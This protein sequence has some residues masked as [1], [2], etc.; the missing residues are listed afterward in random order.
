MAVSDAFEKL[1]HLAPATCYEPAEEVGAMGAP[2][3]RQAHHVAVR[4]AHHV[5]VG[6]VP[7]DFEGMIQYATL[8]GGKRI[9]MLK[10][11]LTS[12]CERNCYYCPFRAGR[13]L[14]RVTF[15]PDEL[16]GLFDRLYRAGVV[17]GIFLSSGIAGGSVRIQDRLIATAEILRTRYGFTGYI[18]LKL[19][20]GAEFAQVERSMQLADRVSVNLEAP[21]SAT[22]ARLAPHKQLVE[23]LVQPLRHVEQIRRARGGQPGTWGNPYRSGP[24]QTTQFVVGP[25]GETDRELLRTTEYLRRTVALARAYFSAFRPV[26]DT[27]LEDHPVTLA[28]RERR[29]YQSDFLLRDYDF[30]V[31]ELIFEGDGNLPLGED[32]K[33][34]WARRHLSHAPVEINRAGRRELLRLPGI[35]PVGVERILRARRLGHLREL[36]D[37]RKLGIMTERAAP[38]ILLD[39]RRPVHQLSFW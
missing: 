29:L 3:V 1:K 30:R 39:G 26:P 34:A 24:S 27:P 14:R 2:V 18:H 37:L 6:P 22:L 28:R 19:M 36:S 35:G 20:P 4:Q 9:P 17:Q 31:D 33:L 12:A 7:A 5:A 8:P 10:T 15:Q 32:P 16:S 21:T 38:F 11:L 25:G 23:E 13:D